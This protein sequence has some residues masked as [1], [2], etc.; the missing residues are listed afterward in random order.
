VP[1]RAH[2]RLGAALLAVAASAAAVTG[3][4]SGPGAGPIPRVTGA[5]GSDPVIAMPASDP[6]G[7]LV[8]RTL[9]DGSGPVVHADDY[10][11]VNVEGKV[12]AGDR[13]VVD[14]FTDRQPQG[15][16][17][18]TAM[19]AWRHLA[20]QRVGSR[21]LMVVPPADGFG[22]KG[23]PAANIMG[24]DTLVFVFDVVAAVPGNAAANGV[25]RPA[26]SAAG[27]P[28]VS[29][30]A[31]GVPAISVPHRRPPTALVSEV[32]RAGTGPELVSGDTV[33][34]QSLGVVWRTGA[35]FD[36]TWRRGCPEAFVLGSG[37]TLPGWEQGLGGL[38]VGTRVLLVIP[39]SL[40]FGAAAQPPLI[41]SGDTLVYVIDIVAKA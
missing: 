38:R 19:P 41:A 34:V 3:C 7:A 29:V 5:Y 8:V 13:E 28:A 18:S 21:V 25:A 35:V 31:D 16:P 39:P 20:G 27:L 10:V 15:L 17:L 23:D 40:G 11:L 30:G 9:I 6:T 22:A 32:L 4:S 1:T 26:P 33:V 2:R 12:W 36:S 37:Q 24:S 14:S